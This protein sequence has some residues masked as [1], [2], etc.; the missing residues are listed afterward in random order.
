MQIDRLARAVRDTGNPS[1][2]G[3]DTRF[4]YIPALF[5]GKHGGEHDRAEAI[6]A[7]N[8]ELLRG[9]RDIIPCVKIQAACYEMLG[10][11]GM[12][13]M[14]R[15]IAEA[16]RL[17]FVV[18]VDAKRG[19]IGATAAAYSAAYLGPGAPYE[20]DFLTVNP[21]FGQ[22]GVQPFIEDCERT[23]RGI[24]ALVKTSNPS[25]R[26][27]QD[28]IV[29]D[30]RPL[31]EH[32]AERVSSWGAASVSVE[33]YSSVGAVVG[34]TYPVQGARL[35]KLMPHTFFLL[36]GYGAQ[37][38]AAADLAGC[39]DESGGGAIVAA[40]RSIICA[41]QK[42]GTGDFVGAARS[43]AARMRS[44]LSSALGNA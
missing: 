32:V 44:E 2:L 4:E 19:D 1:A 23:G 15:S 35:R 27:F 34:A 21:Y 42:A 3:L 29:E 28:L 37:G 30:G 18:I 13:C 24:F 14:E 26:E 11:D 5:A 6:Y 38:A 43:E 9:L 22:D 17:D 40:S 7:F 36:P 20:A 41:H 8:A 16:R 25:G 10:A 33:G 39:F 31:Y 12:D